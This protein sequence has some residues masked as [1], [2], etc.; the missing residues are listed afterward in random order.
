[1]RLH[2]W[3]YGI[4]ASVCIDRDYIYL[5]FYRHFSALLADIISQGAVA[6]AGEYTI[7]GMKSNRDAEVHWQ[8]ER[9][10]TWIGPNTV[11]LEARVRPVSAGEAAIGEEVLVGRFDLSTGDEV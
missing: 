2:D 10:L 11:T 7:Q 3:L 6:N 4:V 5:A 9:R 8:L 1:M